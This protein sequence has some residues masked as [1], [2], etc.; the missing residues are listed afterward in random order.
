MGTRK[1]KNKLWGGRFQRG[2]ASSVEAFTASIEWDSCLAPY[3]IAGSMAHAEM[4]QMRGLLTPSECEKIVQGL[5]SIQKEIE[6]DRFPY[7]EEYEDIHMNIEA[8]LTEKIGDVAGKLHAG[9]SRN[10][11]VALDLRLYVRDLTME[12]VERLFRLR[13]GLL[14]RAEKETETILPAYTHL[15]RAQPVVLAHYLLA[16][17]AMFERDTQRLL[18]SLSRVNVSPLGSG[19]LAGTT[20]P[21]DRAQTARWLGFEK[22]SSN[23]LDAVSDR[24]FVVEYLGIAALIMIHLSR[25]AEEWIVWN[26]SEFNFIEFPDS[27]CTGSSMMP[28]KKNPDVLELIRGRSGRVVGGWVSLITLLKGLPLSYNRDLQEDKKPLFEAADVVL[29]SLDMM[30][31]AVRKVRF[32][33]GEMKRA[34][35]DGTLLATDLAEHLVQKGIPFRKAHEIVG[36]IV[37]A[38]IKGDL[39]LEKWTSSKLKRFSSAFDAS[40]EKLLRPEASVRARKLF[41]GTAPATVRRA[42]RE[43]KRA[44]R[45]QRN[46]KAD[47]HRWSQG[48][49]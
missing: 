4:L 29:A 20:L 3:D 17:E 44:L 26:S 8:R 15:Q 47:R 45:Y 30:A 31:E 22:L 16:Y 6:T 14:R 48:R 28:Q 10:D 2:T 41:G 11:Q 38:S 27:F 33:R 49:P 23:S 43:A 34:A 42:I 24:D 18:E 25:W 37:S 36:R 19:A 40:A 7:R 9:R 35:Q 39:P 5:M 12:T 1:G 46:W 13:E 21:L 32:K